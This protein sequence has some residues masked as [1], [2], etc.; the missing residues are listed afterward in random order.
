MKVE[1]KSLQS[2][3][4]AFPNFTYKNGKK[5]AY[6]PPKTIVIGPPEP[7]SD[8]LLLH[9]LS[10]AILKHKSFKM[11]A[12]RLRIES[13]A[14]N[15]AKELAFSLSIPFDED[16]AESKLDS[17]RDWLHQKSLCKSCGLTRFQAKNGKYYCPR[18]DL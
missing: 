8:L 5:F 1:E 15:K 14:W 17:Y 13:E 9:E 2:I 12:E 10:H 11:D 4:S 18:C 3:I 7:R 6:A 16:F